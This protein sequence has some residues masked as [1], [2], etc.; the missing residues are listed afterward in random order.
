MGKRCTSP[1]QEFEVAGVCDRFAFSLAALVRMMHF[2]FE[3]CFKLTS[4]LRF[5][6]NPGCGNFQPEIL[7][8]STVSSPSNNCA[9]SWLLLSK[10][11]RN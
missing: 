10:L 2:I 6:T 8:E 1:D 9:E 3:S 7:I 11:H 5:Q 4:V